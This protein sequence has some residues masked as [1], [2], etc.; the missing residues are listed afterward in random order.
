MPDI[1]EIW[2]H[3]F[4]RYGRIDDSGNWDDNDVWR[5]QP[6]TGLYMTP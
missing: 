6:G 1:V 2:G 5:D 3:W 4:L